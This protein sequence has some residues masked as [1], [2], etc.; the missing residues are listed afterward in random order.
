MEVHKG[1]RGKKAPYSTKVVRIPE[2]ILD[3]VD[4]LVTSFY[5]VETPLEYTSVN[6]QEAIEKAREIL[7]SKKSAKISLEKLLQ[8]LYNNKSIKL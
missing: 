1:G 3:K 8:V 5:S 7:L 6:L 4:K 2:P